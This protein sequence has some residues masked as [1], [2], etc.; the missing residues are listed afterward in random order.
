MKYTAL[1]KLLALRDDEFFSILSY[2]AKEAAEV[3]KAAFNFLKPYHQIKTALN[4]LGK[5]YIRNLSADELDD[6]GYILTVQKQTIRFARRL[7]KKVLRPKSLTHCF[8][9]GHFQNS[10]TFGESVSNADPVS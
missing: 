1:R 5:D 6:I 10:V 9:A 4:K 7:K 8:P 3:E 2:G